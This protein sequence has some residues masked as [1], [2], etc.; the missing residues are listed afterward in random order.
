MGRV[1][2]KLGS[3]VNK[4]HEDQSR[5]RAESFVVGND[6]KEKQETLYNR[7]FSYANMVVLWHSQEI[8]KKYPS[9]FSIFT[10]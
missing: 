9:V 6:L 8:Y 7:T 1:P 10:N 5:N 2:V 3:S 4:Q